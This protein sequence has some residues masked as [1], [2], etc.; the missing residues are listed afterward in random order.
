M[1]PNKDLRAAKRPQ[2]ARQYRVTDK[3]NGQMEGHGTY[4][5]SENSITPDPNYVGQNPGR[6]S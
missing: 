6:A 3:G 1:I 4:T 5:Q 2:K